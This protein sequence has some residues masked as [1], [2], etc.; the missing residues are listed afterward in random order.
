MTKEDRLVALYCYVCSC[1][2]TELSAHCQR[3]SNHDSPVFTD[4]EVITIFLFAM[5]E[6]EKFTTKQIYDH[7]QKYWLSWFPDLPGYQQFNKRLN[8][9]AAVF[10][11]FASRILSEA[12]LDGVDLGT[13]LG[14]SMPIVLAQ[15]SRS[16]RA[17]VAPALCNQGYCASKKR[18]YC[19][20][21]A[22]GSNY[23][24]WVFGG[25]V[26]CP[27]RNTYCLPLLANTTSARCGSYFLV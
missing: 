16:Y 15:K 14:D 18:T 7:T 4:Q 17:Q 9:L 8:R 26:P 2:D 12:S 23:I 25:P 5:L 19:G 13:S 24:R 10:P 11:V 21:W 3:F 1:Y 20:L 27:Y 6:D 22:M